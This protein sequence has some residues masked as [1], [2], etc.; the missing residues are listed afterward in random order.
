M[1]TALESASQ[2]RGG[3]EPE[4]ASSAADSTTSLTVCAAPL[5]VPPGPRQAPCWDTG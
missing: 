1:S 5:P 4:A 3:L 2:A